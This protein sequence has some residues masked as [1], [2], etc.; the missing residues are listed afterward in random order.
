M[1]R[2]TDSR[3]ARNSDSVM[4]GRPPTAG[5]PALA[6]ALLLGLEPGRSLDRGHVVS[7]VC[8]SR[9][10]TTVSGGSSTA[11]SAAVAVPGPR[12]GGAYGVRLRPSSPAS[13]SF[14][15][16]R[17]RRRRR[18]CGRGVLRRSVIGALSVEPARCLRARRRPGPRRPSCCAV[19][20]AR[21]ASGWPWAALGVLGPARLVEPPGRHRLRPRRR[22][23]RTWLGSGSACACGGAAAAPSSSALPS[24]GASPFASR[25]TG[26]NP[27]AANPALTNRT[28]RRPG[29]GLRARRGRLEHHLRWLER[30]RRPVAVAAPRYARPPLALSLVS[31]S[32][33]CSLSEHSGILPSGSRARVSAALRR[34]RRTPAHAHRAGAHCQQRPCGAVQ[35]G[36]GIPRYPRET[37][38]ADPSSRHGPPAPC[39]S[40]PP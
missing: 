29:E 33:S 3:R 26:T 28:A 38:G 22:S 24:P 23:P 19:R 32:C 37:G 12:R 7:G 17:S 8:G 40:T 18:L 13:V 35:C 36:P 27:A 6:A 2:S 30:G 10:W 5:F 25:P 15:R 34:R 31:L 21:L 11:R 1:V 14:A 4:I 20:G 39:R 16:P 9:T